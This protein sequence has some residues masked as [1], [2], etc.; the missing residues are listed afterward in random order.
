MCMVMGCL[1]WASAAGADYTDADAVYERA[2]TCY[3]DVKK[4]P[5]KQKQ[6]DSWTACIRDF[7]EVERSYATS[8]RAPEARFSAG[9]MARDYAALYDEVLSNTDRGIAAKGR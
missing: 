8:E 6:R 4:S 2:R 7:L 9:R 3:Q 5:E 1:S